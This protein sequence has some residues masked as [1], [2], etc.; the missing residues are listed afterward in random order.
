M[1]ALRAGGQVPAR[2]LSLLRMCPGRASVSVG[3]GLVASTGQQTLLETLGV[4]IAGQ[5]AVLDHA[6]PCQEQSHA[7][8]PTAA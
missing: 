8:R 5:L 4:G 6:S 7:H 3:T 1:E 2:S